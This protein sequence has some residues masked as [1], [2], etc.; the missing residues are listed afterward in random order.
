LPAPQLKET[1]QF[2]DDGK[3]GFYATV[4]GQSNEMV[5]Q[6]GDKVFVDDTDGHLIEK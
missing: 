4:V 6:A 1:L 3:R 5:V 2:L